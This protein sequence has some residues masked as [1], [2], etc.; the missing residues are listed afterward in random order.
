MKG[1]QKWFD[2]SCGSW[3]SQRRYLFAPRFEA[4]DMVTSFTLMPT[5]PAVY[6]VE[7][8]GLTS[9]TMTLSLNEDQTILDRSRDYFDQYGEGHSSRIKMIDDDA[10]V[11]FTEYG[12]QRFRE[13]IRLIKDD[14]FR[15]RQ[16]V[17]LFQETNELSLV[18][19]YWESRI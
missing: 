6:C 1:P 10:I 17:G 14:Q 8:D 11:L 5:D 7:W 15:L 12:G 3:T 2:R 9:G 19:Q 18:G 13:E 4:K 16:T